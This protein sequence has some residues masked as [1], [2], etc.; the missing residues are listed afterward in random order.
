MSSRT[1]AL[2]GASAAADALRDAHLRH[3]ERV[4]PAPRR[5]HAACGMRRT[6]EHAAAEGLRLLGEPEIE[7]INDP[8]YG[9]AE[10]WNGTS[11]EVVPTPDRAATLKWIDAWGSGLWAVGW[12]GKTGPTIAELYC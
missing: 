10:H 3:G 2:P 12:R 9:L 8:G 11:W 6:E 5:D 1:V 4:P 7:R